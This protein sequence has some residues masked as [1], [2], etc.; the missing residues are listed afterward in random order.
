M[1][2]GGIEGP[3][4]AELVQLIRR[5]LG[6][7]VP[8][9]PWSYLWTD[10]F[11]SAELRDVLDSVSLVWRTLDNG[12]GVKANEFRQFVTRAFF[13]ESLGYVMDS[14]GGV[15]YG[16]DAEYERNRFSAIDGLGEPR[17]AAV[18]AAVEAAFGRL[19]RGSDTKAAV[20][21]M[22]EAAEILAKLMTDSN[23]DLSEKMVR[24]E[25]KPL[26]QRL[27]KK[28][29]SAQAFSDLMLESFAKWVAAGHRYRH[30]QATEEPLAPPVDMA[31]AYLS[32]GAS[33][34]RM[35]VTLDAIT[36]MLN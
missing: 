30:G 7:D 6:V 32:S 16:V 26:A 22:F 29:A 8:S 12:H 24:Q 18:K 13:D 2:I 9:G 23:V 5:E 31:V 20:R 15:R 1:G 33:H 14:K 28:D 34:I 27:Y 19:D 25:I 4:I 10:Y 36:R 3:D 21:E 35:L 11:G 17:Y